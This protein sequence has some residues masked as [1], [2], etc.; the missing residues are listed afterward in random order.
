MLH[1]LALMLARQ[2]RLLVQGRLDTLCGG[3]KVL[4]QK[5]QHSRDFVPHSPAQGLY[6]RVFGGAGGRVGPERRGLTRG[7]GVVLGLGK[8][9]NRADWV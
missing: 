7:C 1:K 6:V 8:G 9:I 5:M 4:S 2:L 3:R